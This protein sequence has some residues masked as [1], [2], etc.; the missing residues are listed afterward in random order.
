MADYFL[1]FS[2]TVSGLSEPEAAWLADQL[3]CVAVIDGVEHPA[4]EMPG[5]VTTDQVAWLGP[6]F[7]LGAEGYED[8][9]EEPA[10]CFVFGIDDDEDVARYLWLYSEDHADLD[11]VVLLVQKFLQAFRPTETWTMTYATTC[12]KPRCG[13]FGGGAGIVTADNVE[14]HDAEVIADAA[15]RQADSSCGPTR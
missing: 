8:S 10:F 13:A 15:R 3:R 5:G 12:S 14:W 4:D 2:E 6:R 9:P 1:Q 11:Q 7:L